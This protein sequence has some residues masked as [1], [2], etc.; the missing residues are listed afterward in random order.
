MRIDAQKLAA[1]L[2][3]G[4]WSHTSCYK[5]QVFVCQMVPIAHLGDLDVARSVNMQQS[6]IGT[7]NR[8]S[9]QRPAMDHGANGPWNQAIKLFG[10]FG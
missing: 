7:R 5:L 10:K 4:T 8:L 6:A 2:Q 1:A 9:H 3:H